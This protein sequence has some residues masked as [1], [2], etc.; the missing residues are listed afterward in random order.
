MEFEGHDIRAATIE[1]H[2]AIINIRHDIYHGLDYVP[3]ML[4]DMLKT[5]QCFV[6]AVKDKIVCFK[7]ICRYTGTLMHIFITS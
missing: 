4:E 3:A 2:D 5:H 1:D 7:I 6:A